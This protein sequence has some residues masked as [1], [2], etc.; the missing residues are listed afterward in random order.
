MG[1]GRADLLGKALSPGNKVSQCQ[2]GPLEST[3]VFVFYGRSL[4]NTTALFFINIRQI[5]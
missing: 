5:L 3:L 4:S 1:L 2:A